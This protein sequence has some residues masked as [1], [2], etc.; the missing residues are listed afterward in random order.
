MAVYFIRPLLS[1]LQSI[2]AYFAIAV[3]AGLH[4]GWLAKGTTHSPGFEKFKR[5]IGICGLCLAVVLVGKYIA[6]GPGVSWVQFS[7]TI[8]EHAQQEKKPVIIDFYAA[9]CTPC[10]ELDATTFHNPEVVEQSEKL[11]MIKVDLTRGATAEYEAL[12]ERFQIKGVPTILF[13]G[14]DGKERRALRLVD[15]LGSAEF[16]GR[17]KDLM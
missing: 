17:M 10:R 14:A 16:L 11:V 3:G 4:L 8:L 15:Y 1:E 5:V 9:W 2:A 13:L 6:R 12:I 7:D